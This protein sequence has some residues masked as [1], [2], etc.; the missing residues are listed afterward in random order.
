MAQWYLKDPD[1]RDGSVYCTNRDLDL[2]VDVALATGR[3][4]LV[5]GEPGSGKSTLAPYVARQRKWR[6]YEY[7]VTSRTQATDLL[8]T[9]DSVRRLADA[10][11]SRESAP[12][13]DFRYIEPGVLWWAFAPGSAGRR[14]APAGPAGA[15]RSASPTRRFRPAV[16]PMRAVNEQRS[17]DHAVVLIDEI[18]KADPDM[19][20]SLLVPL[21]SS[22]FLVT[23]TGTVVGK[24]AQNPAGVAGATSRHLIVVTTNEE[25]QLPGAFV[26]RCVVL[27]LPAPTVDWL[28]QVAAEHL[29]AAGETLTG[30]IESLA[31][32]LAEELI[33]AREAAGSEAARRPS[34]AEYLDALRACLSLGITIGDARW[35][36]IRQL[37]LVKRPATD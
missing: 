26:R 12:L 11:A 21:G 30:E 7:V 19:P 14:G 20:N 13:D 6:Y 22:E 2:A 31:T 37:T 1:R 9:F 29:R 36:L 18:D 8:W 27:D 16:E 35:E 5:T 34:T 3:P 23:E 25:R 32:S 24:E 28:R 17:R 15:A 10:Q 33:K 4:L